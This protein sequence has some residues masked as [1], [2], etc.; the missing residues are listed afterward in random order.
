M[1]HLWKL[2]LAMWATCGKTARLMVGVPDYNSYVAHCESSHPGEKIMTYE[3]FFSER[4]ASRYGE[5][6]GKISRCC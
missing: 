2:L 5:S 6:G 3:E 1:R 4:Q